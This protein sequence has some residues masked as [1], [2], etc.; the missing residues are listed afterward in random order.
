[1][2]SLRYDRNEFIFNFCVVLAE[3]EDFSTYKSVVQKLA[4]LMHGLEE[5]NGLIPIGNAYPFSPLRVYP[6]SRC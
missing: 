3:E 2:K 5:Q 6:N 1:M 4:D